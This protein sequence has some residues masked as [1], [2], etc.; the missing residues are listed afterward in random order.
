MLKIIDAISPAEMPLV[1]SLFEE[2][3]ASLDIDLCFQGFDRELETL[4]GGYAPPEGTIVIAFIDGE[5][6]GVVALR[7]V[8]G[9]SCEMKRL[10]VRPEHRGKGVGRA[11]VLAVI[12]RAKEIG[13]AAMKL[14]TLES[15]TEA[16]ALYAS[17][18]FTKCAPYRYNPCEGPVFL[19]LQLR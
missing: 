14:D 19:E 10:F 7:P 5:A 15:M 6:A 17:V 4:P 3:A 1:R 9:V 8:D 2:Y 18:G 16:N 11:L 12:E 13:Y